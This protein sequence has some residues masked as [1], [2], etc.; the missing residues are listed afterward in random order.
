MLRQKAKVLRNLN[1]LLDISLTILSFIL[2]SY[3]VN[4][5]NN[6]PLLISPVN[7]SLLLLIVPLWATILFN[8]GMYYSQRIRTTAEISFQ[9]VKTVL[10]GGLALTALIFLAKI[11]VGR[12]LII[13][14]L[15]INSILL[16]SQRILIKSSLNRIREKGYNNY[17]LLIVGTG[18]RAQAF[19][20]VIKEHKEWGYKIVGFIDNDPSKIGTEIDG[21]EVLGSLKDISGILNKFLIDEVIFIIPRRWINLLEEAMMSC[22]EVGVRTRLAAD[23]FLNKIAKVSF[24][25]IGSWPL[26]TFDPVPYS[27]YALMFKRGVDILFSLF[28]IIATAPFWAIIALLIKL[29]SP[30]PILFKQVRLGLHGRRFNIYK[31]RTMVENAESLQPQL[32]TLNESAG[33]VFK[34]KNDPRLTRIGKFLRK[35]SLDE[36]PQFVNVL[37]GEMSVVGPRPPM[38]C[39]V[40]KYD[41]WQRRRLSVRPGITCL[42]QVMGRNK[43]DFATWMKLDLQYIDTWSLKLDMKIMFKTINSILRATGQ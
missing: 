5:I 36:L 11:H 6:K 8:A 35:L 42:W 29:E 17:H 4:I 18:K 38:P 3:L 34:I 30:G 22:E 1:I 39:E 13:Y 10:I 37:V 16:I 26:L 15:L 7:F 27:M 31:F 40:A 19:T 21:I 2:S 24:D 28:I 43:I 33:P 14:F 23:L 32:E 9:V 25:E 20:R 41:K 12:S